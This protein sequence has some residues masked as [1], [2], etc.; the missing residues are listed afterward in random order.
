[1]GTKLRFPERFPPGR[2][3]GG[4]LLEFVSYP[5]QESSDR[6]KRFSDIDNNYSVIC[7]GE[8]PREV[9]TAD[10]SGDGD[11]MADPSAGLKILFGP[12]ERV[13]YRRHGERDDVVVDRM[14]GVRGGPPKSADD[15]SCGLA[16]ELRD[17]YSFHFGRYITDVIVPPRYVD[18]DQVVEEITALACL[19]STID[20]YGFR[21]VARH[22]DHE[23]IAHACAYS[24]RS[25]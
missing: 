12:E 19:P 5:I 10:R 13:G 9:R 17:R 20:H 21:I 3:H 22:D 7:R 4:R 8:R 6:R 11:Q 1:M 24:N 23:H 25:C 2:S 14:V 15:V 16:H 18:I